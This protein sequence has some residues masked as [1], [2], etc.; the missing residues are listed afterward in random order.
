MLNVYTKKRRADQ[1]GKTFHEGW[2]AKNFTRRRK[3]LSEKNLGYLL[4]GEERGRITLRG[5]SR[6]VNSSS[7]VW[8]K[9]HFITGHFV[10]VRFS[11]SRKHTSFG[12]RKTW[13]FSIKIREMEKKFLIQFF[14]HLCCLLEDCTNLYYSA[15]I[16]KWGKCA[17]HCHILYSRTL[18]LASR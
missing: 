11:K 7:S 17:Y 3:T 12:R 2:E 8:P 5:N 13:T 1:K 6:C 10:L 15:T 4:V 18:Y 9:K 16:I 14:V